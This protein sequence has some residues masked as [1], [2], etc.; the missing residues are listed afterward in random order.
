MATATRRQ[1]RTI[2]LL[3]LACSG[4]DPHS[5]DTMDHESREAEAT[6]PHGGRLLTSGDLELELAIFER[7]VPPELRA[8]VRHQGRPLS[9]EDVS[10]RVELAR[11]GGRVDSISFAPEG[12]S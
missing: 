9:P 2:L 1:A 10:L 7:G 5:A 8:W 12:G 6:G 4:P 3:L 11:L